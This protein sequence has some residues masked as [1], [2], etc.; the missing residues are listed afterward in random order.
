MTMRHRLL[1]F[2]FASMIGIAAQAGNMTVTWTASNEN[3]GNGADVD[4]ASY[5]ID[6]LTSVS[7][8]AGSNSLNTPK[9]YTSGSAV[10]LYPGN[11]MTVS[12]MG[13]TQIVLTFGDG[14]SSNTISTSTGNYSDGTWM[15]NANDVSFTVEGS[16]KHRRIA[17]ISVTYTVTDGTL[18]A[19]TLSAPFTFWPN[20][21]E[22]PKRTIS[23]APSDAGTTVYYT[24]DGSNP[25]PANGTAITAKKDIT[26]SGTTT[27]RAI[28]MLGANTSDEVSATYT[29]GETVNSIA[30]FKRLADGTEARLFLADAMNA[31][32]IYNNNGEVYLRDKTG[33]ICLFMS[34]NQFNPQPA[35][36]QHVAGWIIGKYTNYKG[37]PEF[38]STGNT[39]TEYILFADPVSEPATE[40]LDI[41]VEEFGAYYAD[42]VQM[43]E[44]EVENSGNNTVLSKDGFSYVLYNK[45]NIPSEIYVVPDVGKLVN[46]SGI[47]I[48]YGDKDEIAPI[49]IEGYVPIEVV[50]DATSILSPASDE[51]FEW[52]DLEVFNLSGQRVSI[53]T[54]GF[55]IVNGKKVFIK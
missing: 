34:S 24:I 2:L 27:V 10:R 23:I 11:T 1:T 26:I 40:P 38:I 19:P 28:A 20:T 50:G 41:E 25:S 31:R 4:G 17:G 46:V 7:F 18:S 35:H 3:L 9:Y 43:K 39:T 16:S 37:L 22:T 55:Y 48:P 44:L 32:V 21:T 33:A 47:A 30:A 53:P 12:G 52:Y 6:A 29:L 5:T 15:G 51:E 8:A 42:W 36:N 14:D 13:I 54:T 49:N 45:F